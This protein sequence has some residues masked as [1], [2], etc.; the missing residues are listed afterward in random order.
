MKKLI[1][2]LCLFSFTIFGQDYEPNQLLVQLKSNT[3][4]HSFFRQFENNHQIEFK[5]TACISVPMNIYS[6]T[7]N[8]SEN[9]NDILKLLQ[10]ETNVTAVQFNHYVLERETIPNDPLLVANQWHLKKHGPN[11]RNN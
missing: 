1:T 3:I 9:I 10:S 8:D 6:L 11:R 7:F 4:E 2:L 5:S